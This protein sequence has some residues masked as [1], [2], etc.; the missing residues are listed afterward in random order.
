MQINISTPN[1]P[2]R[3]V[4][5]VLVKNEIST[6]KALE[7]LGIKTLSPVPHPLL[8]SEVAEHADMLCCYIGDGVCVI[9]PEQTALMHKLTQKGF[10]VYESAPLREDYPED[11][12]L[13]FA[14]TRDRIIGNL[15]HADKLLLYC[16]N[17]KKRIDVK[18]GYAKCSTC[19]V[20]DNA[21]I[22][23]DTG[24]HAALTRDGADVLLI[25]AGDVLLS[26]RHHGFFGGAAGKIGKNRLAINGSLCYH[27]DGE[28]IKAF[29]HQY[30]VEA[31]ELIDAPIKDIGGIIPLKEET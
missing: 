13:N 26:D 5:L 27:G 7:S 3:D 15:K 17:N 29:L 8:D 30:N 31:V 6:V 24:I 22:T 21:F 4:G 28:R 14:V 23:E 18:Q 1:L 2:D 12:A 9:S 20:T 25:S 10:T 16:L 19:V 11:V